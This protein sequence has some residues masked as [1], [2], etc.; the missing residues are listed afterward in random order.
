VRNSLAALLSLSLLGGCAGYASDYWKAKP[1]LVRSQLTRYALTGGPGQCV[2]QRLTKALSVWQLRQLAD[3]A[4]RL[5]PPAG[6]PLGARDFAYVAG[7][8][9]DPAVGA[10]VGRALGACSIA[11]AQKA[12]QTPAAP[13][14]GARAPG[15]AAEPVRPLRWIDLGKAETGQAIAIDITSVVTTGP[16]R[17]A[18]FRLTDPGEAE[19]QPVGYHL[20]VDCTART[21]TPT[22]ARKYKPDGSVDQQEDYGGAWQS[23]LPIEPGTVMEI[24]FK[25]VCS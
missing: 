25:R 20:R 15:P 22:G 23:P 24:A 8:V 13:I 18:W 11:T 9:K 3:V 14:E 4:G 2:E 16:K 12:A 7:L 5:R 21:I 1:S 17:E 19:A 6:G 10:E